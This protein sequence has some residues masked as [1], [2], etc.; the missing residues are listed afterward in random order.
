MVRMM[1]PYLPLLVLH[2]D[3]QLSA[4]C[5]SAVYQLFTSDDTSTF[6]W[7]W[8]INRPKLLPRGDGPHCCPSADAMLVYQGQHDK[9]PHVQLG[10]SR[11][12]GKHNHHQIQS[13]SVTTPAIVLPGWCVINADGEKYRCFVSYRKEVYTSIA[14]ARNNSR[15][16]IVF[17]KRA[18]LQVVVG[19]EEGLVHPC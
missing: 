8:E 16:A 3:N 13:S 5:Q 18:T 1:L 4:S 6:H 12:T 17:T 15:I 2:R 10:W 19:N 7:F 11:P 14:T 9:E